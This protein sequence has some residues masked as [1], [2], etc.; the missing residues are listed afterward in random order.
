VRACVCTST[1]LDVNSEKWCEVEQVCLTMADK[2]ILDK[3]TAWLNDRHVSVAQRLIRRDH[4]NIVGLQEPNSLIYRHIIS[5][6]HR[7][8]L[9]TLSIQIHLVHQNHW[10]VSVY[11][12]EQIT[13]SG[14]Y[15]YTYHRLV[16]L[17]VCLMFTRGLS[18]LYYL[19]GH[20]YLA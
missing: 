17:A 16:K 1:V 19:F 7:H 13:V 18:Y 20:L 11:D 3:S 4:P 2:K 14:S 12:A 5:T 10:L 9:D 8:A 15:F 6:E